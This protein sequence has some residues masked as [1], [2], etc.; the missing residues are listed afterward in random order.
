MSGIERRGL[1]LQGR[2]YHL[3]RELAIMRVIDRDQTKMVAGFWSTSR[4]NVRLLKLTR[5][6]LLRRFFL[7]TKGVGQQALYRLSAKGA[8]T[9]G[10]PLRGPHRRKDEFT[11]SFFVGHQLAV[12][13]IYCALKYNAIPLRDVKFVRWISF[14]V[15]LTKNIRIIPDGYAELQTPHGVLAAFLEVDLGY[16]L[17]TVWRT[18]VRYYL[19][20]ALAG[21]CERLFGQTRFLVLV[22]VPTERRLHS[23]R[24][25]VSDETEKIFRFATFDAME[26]EGFFGPIWFRP[27]GKTQE[28]LIK[29]TP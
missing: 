16:E 4:V 10:V 23:I 14:S 29:P 20:F 24:K 26:R 3:L 11:A 13:R 15:P 5:E 1:V 18:K 25:A 19:H 9:V 21:E 6:G 12:N 7:G 8:R 22:L 17:R 28:H 2:D 27:K